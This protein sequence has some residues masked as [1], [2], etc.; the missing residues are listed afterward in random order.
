MKILLSLLTIDCNCVKQDNQDIQEKQYLMNH[1]HQARKIKKPAS[2]IV[3]V[4]SKN[5]AIFE[6]FKEIF[7]NP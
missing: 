2:K 5:E 7:S 1:F 6:N 3:R 4:W